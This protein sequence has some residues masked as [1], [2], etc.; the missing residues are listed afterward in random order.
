MQ[1]RD[2]L[3]QSM[4][5]TITPSLQAAGC[6]LVQLRRIG[7]Q[8]R[9]TIQIMIEH[10]DGSQ[11]NLDEC[12]KIS[13]QCAAVL[14][15]ENVIEGAYVLELSSPGIDRPLTRIEDFQKYAG[16]SAKIETFQGVG[17]RKRFN[18]ILGAADADGVQ[19]QQDGIWVTIPFADIHQARLDV[20]AALLAPKPK[21]GKKGQGA[22][23]EGRKIFAQ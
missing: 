19:L 5:R 20:A 1:N 2:P 11:V 3:I 15:V 12:A 16:Q 6:A 7:G 8:N 22:G 18:G 9:P 13:R 23:G 21:P 10:S 4:I 17:G 14:D